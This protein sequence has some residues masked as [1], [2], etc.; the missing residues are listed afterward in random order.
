MRVVTVIRML[1][2]SNMVAAL[3]GEIESGPLNFTEAD[4][5]TNSRNMSKRGHAILSIFACKQSSYYDDSPPTV[6]G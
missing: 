5:V 2:V 6:Q 3:L 1:I 4:N